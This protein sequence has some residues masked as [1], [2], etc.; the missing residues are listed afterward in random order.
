MELRR[1]PCRGP[2]HCG[3]C[4]TPKNVTGGDETSRRLRGNVVQGWFAPDITNDSR[5]GLGSWSVEEIVNY[6][7]TGHNATAAATGPMAEVV[8]DSTSKMT[9]SDVHAIAEY[10]KD[11]PGET[12]GP[13]SPPNAGVMNLG[14]AIYADE[15][16]ACHASTG[17]GLEG[18]FPSLKGSPSVQSVDP[19][20]LL[21]VVLRGARSAAT[22]A[23]PTAP[24]MPS[25]GWLLTDDQVA[26]VIT[27][28]RNAWGNKAAAVDA[29]TVNKTRHA[30]IE[31]ND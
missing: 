6:L 14:A 9:T 16:A 26:A 15:C 12:D 27:Y 7:E 8:T 23:A 22:D 13:Q 17:T 28:V 25:F 1:L 5:R 19:A 30:L 18:M 4:H 2:A 10:L 29:G 21:R 31:R 11:Q 20:S 24:A 3:L